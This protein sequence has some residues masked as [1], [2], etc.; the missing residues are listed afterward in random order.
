MHFQKNYKKNKA[1]FLYASKRITKNFISK[2]KCIIDV[3]KRKNFLSASRIKKKIVS[4]TT[5]FESS[6]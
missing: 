1:K 6:M 4:D 5:H 2:I 3:N